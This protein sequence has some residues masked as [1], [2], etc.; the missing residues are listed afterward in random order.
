MRPLLLLSVVLAGC[1][2]GTGPQ[3]DC[4]RQAMN[5]PAVAELFLREPYVDRAKLAMVTHEAELRC[6]RAKGLAPPGGVQSVIPR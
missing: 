6:L 1:S 2:S 5:D 3:T 4:E